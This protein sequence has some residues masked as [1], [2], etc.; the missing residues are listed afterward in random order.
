MLMFTVAFLISML[1]MGL[2]CVWNRTLYRAAVAVYTIAFLCTYIQG[3][4]L[5]GRLPPLD[6]SPV[7]WDM[8]DYQ[9]M[10]TVI[11]WVVV[12]ILVL[13]AIKIFHMEKFVKGAGFLSAGISLM[14]FITIIVVCIT[15]KGL[16]RKLAISAST[17]YEFEMSTDQNY[18]ILLLDSVDGKRMSE[19]MEEH[20]E[21][22]E[23]FS[24][25]TCYENTMSAYPYT[26]FSV[27]FII[28]GDWFEC[29]ELIDTYIKNAF[30]NAELFQQLEQREYRMGL[31]MGEAPMTDESMYRFE[32]VV[33]DMGEFESIIDFIKVEMR[34][35]GLKYM[36]YD[37][38]RRCLMLPEEI[39]NLRKQRSDIERVVFT[40]SNIQF[41]RDI[42]E[43]PIT[44]AEEKCFRL[45]H[46]E[47]AH[48]PFCYD[49]NVNVIENGTYDQSME[50]TMTIMDAYLQ[51]LKDSGVYDNS[52]IIVM[53]DHG[54]NYKNVES[55]TPEE[56]QH[57]ILFVKG[58]G[59]QHEEMQVSQAPISQE[60]YTAAYI[61]LM[62]GADSSAIFDYK[63]GDYRERRYLFHYLWD[64]DHMTE[65]VQTG[66]AENM[67][68][69]TLTGREFS[70]D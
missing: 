70:Q 56:R 22:K 53:S 46:L 58:F 38:K 50:A 8:Y 68:T 15:N 61:R 2:L 62:D 5:A 67:D 32:N 40:D 60:D 21:Y 63:E 3:N 66:A 35:V 47:A 54:Y 41:Y 27:P 10:Y 14:L 30:K 23:T 48:V 26:L 65:Y 11:L 33:P 7:S 49:E 42:Q 39:P 37:L 34:L 19:M 36:P 4:Y 28:S 9:R 55:Y 69:M 17:N 57:P 20:P 25:F 18:I 45:I 44:L 59:E 12:I 13:A 64:R 31:Y 24:D 52:V 43:K 51:K 29:D 1:V 16:E 6:G